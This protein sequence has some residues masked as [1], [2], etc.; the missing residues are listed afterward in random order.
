MKEKKEKRTVNP[1]VMIKIFLNKSDTRY[2]V[3]NVI[4]ESA[5]Y[6]C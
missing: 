4:L 6:L 1:N 3:I 2:L 5:I